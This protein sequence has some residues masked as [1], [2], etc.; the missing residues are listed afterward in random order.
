MMLHQ[1]PADRG[2]DHAGAT[3]HQDISAFDIHVV[4]SIG[5]ACE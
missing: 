1:T 4:S 5:I 3:Q 2:T